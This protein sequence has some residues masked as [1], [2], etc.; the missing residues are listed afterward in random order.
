MPDKKTTVVKMYC[1]THD[2]GLVL[3]DTKGRES[4][5]EY[6]KDKHSGCDFEAHDERMIL[7]ESQPPCDGFRFRKQKHA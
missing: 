1:R 7:D 5:F 3:Y 4:W 6:F 2:E